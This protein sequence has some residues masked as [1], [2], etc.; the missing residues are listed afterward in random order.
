[1]WDFA[2]D[3]HS[4]KLIESFLAAGKPIGIVCHSAGASVTSRRQTVSLW[5]KARKSPAPTARKKL[6]ASPK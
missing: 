4:I 1:M 3:K 2:D 5:F 6:S